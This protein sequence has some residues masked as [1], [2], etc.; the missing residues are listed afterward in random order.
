M[1]L[2]NPSGDTFEYVIL[3]DFSAFNNEGEYEALVAGIKMALTI[4]AIKILIYSES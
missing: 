1:V 4:E 3:F 2:T